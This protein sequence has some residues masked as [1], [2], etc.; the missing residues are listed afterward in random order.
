MRIGVLLMFIS[1]LAPAQAGH[2]DC[3]MAESEKAA[4]ATLLRSDWSVIVVSGMPGH[5]PNGTPWS[6]QA[7]ERGKCT[8]TTT[9]LNLNRVAENE[10]LCCDAFL[11]DEVDVP[12]GECGT[13]LSSISF[14]RTVR[15]SSAAR[16]LALYFRTVVGDAPGTVFQDDG[17]NFSSTA[18][19]SKTINQIANLT[20]AKS[21]DG[22][23]LRLVIYRVSFLR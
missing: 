22:Y 19:P 12:H 20:V 18:W 2:S 7:S 11:F 17:M 1:I 5:W 6:M 14:T 15:D 9:L 10:C 4:L 3:A 23:V 16:T 21:R 13:Q 8:G